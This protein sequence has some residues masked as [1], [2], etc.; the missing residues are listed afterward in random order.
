M[1]DD[2]ITEPLVVERGDMLVPDGPGLGV[3]VD[4]QAVQRYRVS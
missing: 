4:W 1:T 3:E 2:L